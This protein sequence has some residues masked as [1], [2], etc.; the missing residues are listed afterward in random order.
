[1]QADA[2][3]LDKDRE[4]RLAALEQR[5]QLAREADNKARE[6]SGKYGDQEF[7]NGLRKQALNL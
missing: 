4:Q 3:E 1:M 5:D 6:R 2:S 7:V